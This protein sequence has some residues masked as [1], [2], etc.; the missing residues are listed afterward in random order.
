MEVGARTRGLTARVTG[1]VDAPGDIAP[2]RVPLGDTQSLGM[3]ARAGH[4]CG[5]NETHVS[6]LDGYVAELHAVLPTVGSAVPVVLVGHSFGG[7]I[8]RAYSAA[9]PE[10]VVG[11]VVVDA[12]PPAV[13]ADPVMKIGGP[14]GPTH[15]SA[16]KAPL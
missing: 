3:V 4:T 10:V 16:P 12:T 7:L 2:I 5:S 14:D 13:A 6:T 15:R 8:A 9:H 11:L 1:L